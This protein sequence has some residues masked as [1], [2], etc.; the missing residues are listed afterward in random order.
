MQRAALFL[1]YLPQS[2]LGQL[3]PASPATQS[4]ATARGRTGWAHK[5]ECSC[6]SLALQF[7]QQERQQGTPVPHHM[8]ISV[9]PSFTAVAN[10]TTAPPPLVSCRAA[11]A[12]GGSQYYTGCRVAREM[13][14]A[15]TNPPPP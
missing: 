4:R 10:V 9:S 8:L 14:E 15:I 5:R 7:K 12:G 6:T 11:A 1:V 3:V 13:C 2:S